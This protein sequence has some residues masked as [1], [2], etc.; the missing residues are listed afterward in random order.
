MIKSFIF[1]NFKS[2]EK[3]EL[4]LESFTT[5]IGTN[6]SG[7]SNA[8][9]GIKILSELST[10]RDISAILD[11]SKNTSSGIRG[12]SKGCCRFKTSAFKLGCL[13]NLDDT[14]DLLYEIKIG[15]GNRIYVEEESLRKMLNGR[16]SGGGQ[17]IFKTKEAA[18]KESGDIKVEYN[19]GKPGMNPDITC[20]RSSAII[21]QMKT[22]MPTTEDV[23]KENAS[24]IELILTNLQ[25]ILFLDPIPSEMRDYVRITDTELKVNCENISAVLKKLCSNNQDKNTLLEI[26][27]SLPE[28]EV[29]DIGFIDTSLGDVIF[30]LEEK[31]GNSSEKVDAKRLSD[32]T[33]R[34]IAI[35]AAMI[36]ENE[37]STIVVEEIDNGIHPS[38]AKSLIESI[39]AIG[40]KRNI[41]III[42]THNATLLNGLSK[43]NLKGVSIVYREGQKG[44]SKFVPFID[45]DKYPKILAMGGLG[46]AVVNDTLIKMIKDNTKNVSDYSWMEVE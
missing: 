6:A 2:F 21:A 18:S 3:A 38:R 33:L 31:Y 30:T 10:G 44:T 26:I 43:N 32:G 22:K 25:N 7:K 36:T 12:G 28:N 15:V 42:T 37:N 14:W 29:R 27:G 41:D 19:N 45:I 20:I 35:V 34:C 23:F 11:G 40:E 17:K 13:V 9:E 8:I 16:I 4:S 39:S 46:D 5:L 24:F 1:E